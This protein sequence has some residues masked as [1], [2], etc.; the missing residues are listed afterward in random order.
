M[1]CRLLLS[2]KSRAQRSTFPR[3]AANSSEIVRR[4]LESREE[5]LFNVNFPNREPR[6]TKATVLSRRVYRDTVDE[7]QDPRGGSYFWIAGTPVWDD[8]EDADMQAVASGL[9]SVTPLQLD[10]THHQQVAQVA[11]VLDLLEST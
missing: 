10:L 7:R 3:T 8:A 1:V 2:V 11:R 6:G 9:V 5:G 4:L